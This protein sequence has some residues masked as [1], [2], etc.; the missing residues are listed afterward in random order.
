[1]PTENFWSVPV[2]PEMPLDKAL[3]KNALTKSTVAILTL[4][5]MA[6]EGGDRHVVK[7]DYLL[8]D[9]EEQNLKLVCQTAHAMGKKVILVLNMG[10]IVDLTQFVALPDAI[11]HAWMGGQEMGN[12]LADVLMGKVNPSG[13]LPLTWALRYA[14]YPSADNFPLSDG[15]SAYVRYAEDVM[16]GY[17]HFNTQGIK[18]LYP[19]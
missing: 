8:S 10:S 14:D 5:R 13:K 17:R 3:V 1:M 4:S 2:I 11:L 18:V 9:V 15:D 16:V 19:F 12:S 7:G 6:G